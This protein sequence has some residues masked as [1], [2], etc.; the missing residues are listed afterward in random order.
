MTLNQLASKI[1]NLEGKKVQVSI[2]NLREILKIIV[3]L[4]LATSGEDMSKDSP[5]YAILEACDKLEMKRLKAG[6]R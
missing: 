2:G 1:A 4:E 3:E 5:V 6:K